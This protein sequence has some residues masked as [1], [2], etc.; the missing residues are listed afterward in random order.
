[1][2]L[3]LIRRADAGWRPALR[4]HLLALDADDRYGR[5]GMVAADALIEAYVAGIDFRSDVC[6]VASDTTGRCCGLIHLALFA[7]VAELGLSVQADCRRR[8]LGQQLL[9][10]ALQHARVRGIT[11]I[12]LVTAPSSVLRMCARL[13]VPYRLRQAY[14]RGV[15]E[16]SGMARRMAL[17]VGS[18]ADPAATAPANRNGRPAGRSLGLS[19]AVG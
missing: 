3:M 14:P 7:G 15:I 13:G 5:F 16:C 12:H 6:V 4:R 10:A 17:A 19:L 2:G 8:G 18:T 1:M 9:A 11:E